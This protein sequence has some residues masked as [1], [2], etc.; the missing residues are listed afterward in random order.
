M[1]TIEIH[2]MDLGAMIICGL[3]IIACAISETEEAGY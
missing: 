3:M 2:V 1:M